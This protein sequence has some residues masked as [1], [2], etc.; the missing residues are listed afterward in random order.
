MFKINVPHPG[1]LFAFR[2]QD[3]IN[4]LTK[5]TKTTVT[6][7]SY[8]AQAPT[9]ANDAINAEGNLPAGNDFAQPPLNAE[10]SKEPASNDP[11]QHS[12]LPPFVQHN[13]VNAA[14]NPPVGNE[15][16]IV[17]DYHMVDV[18]QTLSVQKA[19]DMSLHSTKQP[20]P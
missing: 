10:G 15:D 9:T 19:G 3:H 16:I 2:H 6:N 17:G 18:L 20:S 8:P 13:A 4:F 1:S 5:Q 7:A 12:A 14:V 11:T